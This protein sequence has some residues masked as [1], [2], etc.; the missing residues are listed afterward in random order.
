M[1]LKYVRIILLSGTIAFGTESCNPTKKLAPGQYLVEKV[2]VVNA[3]KTR[4][5]PDNFAD[6]FRQKPNRKFLRTF[7]FYVWWYNLFDDGNIAK[8][9]IK[10]NI[11]YDKKNAERVRKNEIR[12][13]KR[14]KKGK[15]LKDPKLKNKESPLLIESIRDIGEPAVILDSMLTHQTKLQLSKYL[16]RK[17]Y[18]NNS[19]TDSVVFKKNQKKA[20]VKYYLNP[21]QV[22]MIDKIKYD[23]QDDS[24][25]AIVLKD[26]VNTLV[27]AGM[28]YD[29]DKLQEERQRNTDLALKNGYYFFDNVYINYLADTSMANHKVSLVMRLKKFTLTENDSTKEI[30]HHRFKIGKVLVITES[31]IGDPRNLSFKDTIRSEKSGFVF[32]INKDLAYKQKLMLNNISISPGRYYN[33][34]SAQFS[35]KQL[36][37]IGLFRNVNIRFYKDETDQNLLNCYI[38]CNPLLKQSAT[39]ETEGT[40]TSGNLG[41][42]GSLIWLNRN[43]F[44]G[45]EL[46]E[47]KIAG[48]IAAQQPLNAVTSTTSPGEETAGS[49]DRVQRTFNTFQFGPELRFSIPKALFPFTF[50]PHHKVLQPRTYVLAS[51]NYQFRTE[52]KR[53][54]YSIDFG[55]SFKTK[56]RQFSHDFI[57]FEIYYVQAVLDP[58]FKED[59]ISYEDA[60]MLNSFSDHVTTGIKYSI[61]YNSKENSLTGKRPAYYV[62]LNMMESGNILRGLY[63]LSNAPTDTAG[64][65]LFSGIPFAQFLKLDV[66]FRTYV[67]IRKKSR[68]VYRLMTGIGKPLANLGVMPYEQSFYSGGPNSVRAWR[69]R[70]LGPGAYNPKDN[71]TRYDKIGDI[72]IEANIEYRFHMLRN[73]YGALFIDAGNIWRLKPDPTKPGG[74]FKFNSFADQIAIGGGFGLRWD[75]TFFILRLDLA[76]PMKDPKFEPGNRWTFDKQGWEYSVLNFGIGYPF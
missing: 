29:E 25:G 61:T 60:F 32:L 11:R 44:K 15:N 70:T 37:S 45:G 66:D 31:S 71:Q 63:S 76:M 6:F 72:I 49:P 14:K 4:M 19:V 5:T 22:Y 35:Y 8:K 43:T 3:N 52:F 39:A 33:K 56:S 40:N 54:I 1:K 57:P 69:A 48:S 41:I 26:T 55:Y 17:G 20:H 34:D 73:F 13:E 2:E 27:K 64:N 74:E 24:L 53:S 16:F 21:E 42:D 38:V 30:N 65:Y 9:R 46:I 68:M 58:A 59:L 51:L 18:F 75:L 62:R 67:P 50:L 12:N 28:I 23:L 36:L 7:H 10:R 47:L